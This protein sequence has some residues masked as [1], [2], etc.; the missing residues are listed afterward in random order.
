MEVAAIT[1]FG[2]S[3][4]RA[5]PIFHLPSSV[6]MMTGAHAWTE[7]F[8]RSTPRTPPVLRPHETIRV[9]AGAPKCV[10]VLQNGPADGGAAM[11]QTASSQTPTNVVTFADHTDAPFALFNG[12]PLSHATTDGTDTLTITPQ[13][14]GNAGGPSDQFGAL[15]GA[16]V[17]KTG[18]APT[19]FGNPSTATRSGDGEQ[20]QS[21]TCVRFRARPVWW[22]HGGVHQYSTVK[23]VAIHV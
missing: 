14:S 6:R 1:F 15:S 2:C 20:R 18:A 16:G 10:N 12:A 8:R 19:S 22:H 17:I 7:I 11:S 21:A 13:S 5:A 3:R 9:V 4:F 23:H